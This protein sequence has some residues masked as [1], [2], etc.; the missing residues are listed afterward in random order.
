MLFNYTC[1][2]TQFGRVSLSP[3]SLFMLGIST[4]NDVD[5]SFPPNTLCCNQHQWNSKTR[6]H[7]N[8]QGTWC[9]RTLQ[10]SQSFLTE[11]RTFMPRCCVIADERCRESNAGSRR[12]GMPFRRERRLNGRIEFE[13][14]K[15]LSKEG[16]RARVLRP[17][18]NFWPTAIFRPLS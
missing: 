8:D 2:W 7:Q 10:P 18:T 14:R 4:A 3:L 12:F 16:R 13:S 15:A 17:V 5:V 9:F 11:L 1:S 6:D